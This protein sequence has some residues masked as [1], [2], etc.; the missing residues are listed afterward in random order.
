MIGEWAF[1]SRAWSMWH[2][3]RHVGRGLAPSVA[4]RNNRLERERAER[5]IVTCTTH[6]AAVLP[7]VVN[8]CCWTRTWA[9][10]SVL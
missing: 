2:A 5:C 8:V 9:G 7:Y 4:C 3:S 6:V 1:G 10:A